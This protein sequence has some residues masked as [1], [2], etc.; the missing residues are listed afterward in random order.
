MPG[1]WYYTREDIEKTADFLCEQ[2]L[3]G[4]L[5]YISFW[6]SDMQ[7][8][9]ELTLKAIGKYLISCRDPCQHENASSPEVFAAARKEIRDYLRSGPVKPSRTDLSPQEQDVV[10]LKLAAALDNRNISSI[11]GLSESSI[12]RIIC[13]SLRKL[14]ELSGVSN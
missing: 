12:S 4:V 7:A 9:E 1:S 10:S 2:Y 13:Q 8:A 6:V 3:P 11:T 5:R 14:K